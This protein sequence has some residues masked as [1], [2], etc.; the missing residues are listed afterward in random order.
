MSCLWRAFR[1]GADSAPSRPVAD[2]PADGGAHRDADQAS[3]A[4]P[5]PRARQRQRGSAL[6][7][8]QAGQPPDIRPGQHDSATGPRHHGPSRF[9]TASIST[10]ARHLSSRCG[11]RLPAPAPSRLIFV[12]IRSRWH[13]W[14]HLGDTPHPDDNG[15]YA[16]STGDH[17]VFERPVGIARPRP[18]QVPMPVMRDPRIRWIRL[19]VKPEHRFGPQAVDLVS[20]SLRSAAATFIRD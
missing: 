16:R 13:L 9:S 20:E 6:R 8:R 12:R 3:P 2:Q 5:H 7:C 11:V 18:R 19:R 15:V 4:Q 14:R 10:I 17:D 1:R